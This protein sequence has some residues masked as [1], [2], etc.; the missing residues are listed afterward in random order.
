MTTKTAKKTS[1][2]AAKPAA[3][4]AA[5][6]Q[7]PAA[8][9]AAAAPA[10]APAPAAK[11][12]S[13]PAPKAERATRAG[14]A[15]A[16]IQQGKSNVEVWAALRAAFDMPDHHSYY[17]VWYRAKLVQDG[18]ITK[19]FARQH[20]GPIMQRKPAAPVASSPAAAPAPAAKP[21]PQAEPKKAAK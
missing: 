2:P 15:Y 1:R 11:P 4:K 3:K 6:A 21:A 14:L 7:K 12:A 8:K 20:R 10:A 5:P 18:V 13:A 17:P 16:L 19:E 9:P